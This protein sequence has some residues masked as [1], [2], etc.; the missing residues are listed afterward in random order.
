MSDKVISI[1]EPPRN[2]EPPKPKQRK[3]QREEE[4]GEET[5]HPAPPSKG[6]WD[7]RPP[8]KQDTLLGNRFLCRHGGMIFFGPTGVG[9]S[10]LS[11]QMVMSFAIGDE[12]MGI[13]PA[14]PLK[15]VLIQA[16]N[17]EGD[18][19]EMSDGFVRGWEKA[20]GRPLSEEERELIRQNIRII[21]IE[22]FKK[23][24]YFAKKILEPTLRE[25]RPDLVWIDPAFAFVS[26]EN[27]SSS[28]VGNFLRVDLGPLLKKYDAGAVVIH[29]TNKPNPDN[30]HSG[31]E[32]AYL[33]AGSAEWANWARAIIGIQ[34]TGTHSAF[35][36]IA[37]KRGSRLGWK[38]EDGLPAFEKYIAHSKEGGIYWKEATEED[39]EA[40]GGRIPD[41]R[42]RKE[43]YSADEVFEYMKSQ[44][45][46]LSQESVWEHFE[47]LK[48]KD[49]TFRRK[50]ET[51]IK[52][53][54]IEESK[55]EPGKFS[56][57]L[58]GLPS[59]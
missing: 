15:S 16:E 51:L 41:K 47:A 52:G 44:K 31:N 34:S 40:L 17:D 56:P 2:F 50:W 43:K 48:W 29:H 32:L 14:R 10:V 33:M 28:D 37:G 8:E 27:N 42:G 1:V 12:C 45:D 30:A 35:K 59:L 53:R 21:E 4:E 55:M 20:R 58:P 25:H 6:I 7:L 3:S 54:H 26:G 39:V 19:W 38:N 23:G 11:L 9:K 57:K 22:D 49:S 5:Y 18:L 24:A 46:T 13:K 36:L